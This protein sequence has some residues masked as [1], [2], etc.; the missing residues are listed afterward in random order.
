VTTRRVLL[1]VLAIAVAV[2]VFLLLRRD[3]RASAPAPAPAPPAAPRAALPSPP[4]MPPPPASMPEAPASGEAR[5]APP[6]AIEA[7]LRASQAAMIDAARPCLVGRP[8]P[9]ART[10]R[11][12][13]SVDALDFQFT[14]HVHGKRATISDV[15]PNNSTIQDETLEKCMLD[16]FARATFAHDGDDQEVKATLVVDVGDLMPAAGSLPDRPP[17]PLPP[18]TLPQVPGPPPPPS[19][20]AQ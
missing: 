10:G 7:V 15:S 5:P 19:R 4:S 12:D 14:V 13:E 18:G 1:A 9:P 2:S 20:N 16:A 3:D 17:P 6:P 11:T 8:K